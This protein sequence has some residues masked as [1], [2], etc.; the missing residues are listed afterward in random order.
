MVPVHSVI[1]SGSNE[2]DVEDNSLLSVETE[3]RLREKYQ[4]FKK[5]EV[6]QVVSKYYDEL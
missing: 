6:G 4:L 5:T 3:R 1:P 2:N